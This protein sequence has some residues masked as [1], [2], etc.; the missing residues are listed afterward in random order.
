LTVSHKYL[1]NLS[2]WEDIYNEYKLSTRP[3]DYRRQFD[4]FDQILTNGYFIFMFNVFEHAIRSICKAYDIKLYQG[5]QNSLS[6]MCK[7]LIKKLGL[8]NRDK[9]IDLIT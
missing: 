4:Y 9:F 5:Q 8:D 7:G 3:Y 2:W 6:D 1:G